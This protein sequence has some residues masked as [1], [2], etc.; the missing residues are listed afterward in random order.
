[1][2]RRA[3]SSASRAEPVSIE[4][5]PA[6]A[7]Q[8]VEGLTG[9][10]AL[11]ATLTSPTMRVWHSHDDEWLDTVTASAR[12]ADSGANPMAG[13]FHDVRATATATGFLVQASLDGLPGS[14]GRLQVVQVLTVED[15]MVVACEEYLAPAMTLGA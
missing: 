15:G 3:T 12:M 8:W 5:M 4:D 10:W 11:L 9:N 13:G 2:A 6:I 14:S 7:D 1:M